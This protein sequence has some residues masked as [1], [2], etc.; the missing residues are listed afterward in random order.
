MIPP[1]QRRIRWYGDPA[2]PEQPDIGDL[3]VYSREDQPDWFHVVH[4]TAP[5]RGRE[6][7]HLWL[8]VARHDLAPDGSIP[9][10]VMQAWR[11]ARVFQAEQ[12]KRRHPGY[13]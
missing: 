6:V 8:T 3:L 7:H 1:R 9:E 5:V 4:A 13:R 12:R 2:E 10:P 11:T